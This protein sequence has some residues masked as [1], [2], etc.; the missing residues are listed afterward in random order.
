MALFVASVSLLWLKALHSSYTCCIFLYS[1][2]YSRKVELNHVYGGGGPRW[3][4]QKSLFLTLLFI[5][6]ECTTLKQFATKLFL[7]QHTVLP[8]SFTLST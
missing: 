7:P 5:F 3:H 8:L 6:E 2:M 1:L 4:L